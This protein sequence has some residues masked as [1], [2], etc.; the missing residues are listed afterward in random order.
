MQIK[1]A[2]FTISNTEVSKCPLDGK[3]EFAFIGR[4]NVGKSSLINMLTSKKGLAKTSGTPGKTQLINHFLINEH[5][6]LVD[7][8]GYGY[9]KVALAQKLEWQKHLE[10][11]LE[12]RQSLTGLVLVMDVRRPLQPFDTVMLDWVK[13]YQIQCHILITKADKLKRGPAMQALFQVEKSVEDQP[14]ISAQLFSAIN[15]TGLAEAQDKL[16]GWL[17]QPEVT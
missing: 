4:S 2:E 5:W 1:S 16:Y 12:K 14:H 10:H 3:P 8:P 7:L 15:G 13:Q 6:Y 11:Y 9:A 17:H